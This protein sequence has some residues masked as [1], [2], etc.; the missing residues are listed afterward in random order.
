M[1]CRPD[2]ER[3]CFGCCPPIRPPGYDTL[4]DRERLIPVF[5][6]N[7]KKLEY[8]RIHAG[9]ISGEACWGLGFLDE[10]G[11][12][13]GCLLHPAR[14][15]GRDLRDRTGYGDKCRRELCR[16]A[17]FWEEAPSDQ[18]IFLLALAEGLDTF[19]YSSPRANPV[20]PL[21][22]WGPVVAAGLMAECPGGLDRDVFFK[23]WAV[24]VQ[25]LVPERDRY[26]LERR[27]ASGPLSQIRWPEFIPRYFD[28]LNG[29]RAYPPVPGVTPPIEHRPFV[30][31][32]NISRPAAWFL[33][34]ALGRF[35]ARPDEALRL[36]TAWDQTLD[37]AF[38]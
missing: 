19:A 38:A 31:Q 8:N 23:D 5:Q 16:E 36:L 7:R 4:A 12:L 18:K 27:L 35:R 10:V 22:L 29:F 32:L 37:R 20:F 33:R 2:E 21:L 11:T 1:L 34:T 25:P 24:L 15:G 13:A 14:H 3:A 9:E 28:A 17:L 6:E 26:G 30:H